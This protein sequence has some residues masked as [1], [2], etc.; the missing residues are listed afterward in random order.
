MTQK[1]KGKP[2]DAP[3]KVKLSLMI[4]GIV[5]LGALAFSVLLSP[6]GQTA[7]PEFGDLQVRVQNLYGDVVVGAN[8]SLFY[9]GD[10]IQSN[11][12][13]VWGLC[14]FEDLPWNTYN[15]TIIKEEHVPHSIILDFNQS[16]THICV[17]AY[18]IYNLTVNV[19]D[20]ESRER[21]SNASVL[22]YRYNYEEVYESI[23]QRTN[24]SGTSLFPALEYDEYAICVSHENY[25]NTSRLIFLNE[26]LTITL[27]LQRIPGPPA[28]PTLH[29]LWPNPSNGTV[30]L[31]W[32]NVRDAGYYHVFRNLSIITSIDGLLPIALTWVSEYQE[33]LTTGGT[34]YY[35]VV[36]YNGE[37]NSSVSNSENVTVIIPPPM[38]PTLHSISLNPSNGEVYLNWTDVDDAGAYYVFRNAS[39]IN[40]TAGLVPIAI[41]LTSEYQEVLTANGTY[42]YA[43]MASNNGG[44]S[45]LSN[46]VNVTLTISSPTD[47]DG[48]PI[49]QVV[50]IGGFILGSALVYFSLQRR[51]RADMPTSHKKGS[52]IGGQCP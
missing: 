10:L 21:I 30:Y 4:M 12:S 17:L 8:I 45:S 19:T 9:M 26:D 18:N 34:Y 31:N 47:I 20:A 51:R 7:A 29:P 36:A 15:L 6:Q 27:N 32:T 13:D 52:I 5:A 44:N 24:D 33:V 2:L 3:R 1:Q 35:A 43:V 49:V 25:Y 50:L 11:L 42:Y 22:V 37:G 41:V 14:I 48:I 28:T 39:L 38:A 46:N 23:T 40:S 16:Q